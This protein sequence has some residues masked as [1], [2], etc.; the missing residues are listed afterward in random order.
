MSSDGDRRSGIDRRGEDPRKGG[1]NRRQGGNRRRETRIKR[2]IPCEFVDDDKS[3]RGFV[4]D[5]SPKGMFVQTHKPITPGEEIVVTFTPPNF[6]REIEVRACVARN[7]QVPRH[8][9]PIASPGVGLKINMAPAEYFE[10]LASLSHHGDTPATAKTEST[11]LKDPEK[12]KPEQKAK[13]KSAPEEK[14]KP[15]K[16][17]KLPPRMPNPETRY[18]VQAKHKGGPRSR[19]LFFDATSPEHAKMQALEEIDSDWE[20]VAVEVA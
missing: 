8:L 19:S 9:A 18:R 13:P 2:R 7:V 12:A 14:P 6:D 10:Y 4:L 17:R 3:M 15:K 1:S 5:V 20:I 11:P 16:K